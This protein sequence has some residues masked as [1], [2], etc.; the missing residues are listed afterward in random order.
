M[1]AP[2]DPETSV[3]LT[4]SLTGNFS[5]EVASTKGSPTFPS[6]E[7]AARAELLLQEIQHKAKKAGGSQDEYVKAA[8]ASIGGALRSL[9]TAY[10]GR[11]LNFDENEKLRIAYLKS[12][13]EMIRFGSK[14]IDFVKALP[15]T[16]VPTG[17]GSVTISQVFHLADWQIVLLTLSLAGLSYVGYILLV[18]WGSRKQLQSY[19]DQDYERDLYYAQY[20]RRVRAILIALYEELQALY[21]ASFAVNFVPNPPPA[22]QI[23]NRA[24]PAHGTMC[25][26]VHK[27]KREGRI[28]WDLWAL[29]ETGGDAAQHCELWEGER[30]AT[31]PTNPTPRA[32]FRLWTRG[33]GFLARERQ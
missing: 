33:G 13:R 10:S 26:Y 11:K 24:L 7:I 2:L 18:R 20:L 31:W 5:A 8:V 27:H 28:T 14:G 6:R 23:V 22:D 17:L 29:C 3:W 21:L 4:W 16:A 32:R 30:P 19:V 9:H 1:V 25:P 12:A 15:A